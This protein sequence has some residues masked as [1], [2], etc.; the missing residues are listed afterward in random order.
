MTSMYLK[1]PLFPEREFWFRKRFE[2]HLI[3]SFQ[4][5]LQMHIGESRED[6]LERFKEISETLP[7][8]LDAKLK[9][10]VFQG[11]WRWTAETPFLILAT[12]YSLGFYQ[13]NVEALGR[14]FHFQHNSPEKTPCFLYT[15]PCEV[16]GKLRIRLT[17]PD[18]ALFEHLQSILN[19]FKPQKLPK[20]LHFQ[21][22]ETPQPLVEFLQSSNFSLAS[23]ND[24][25]TRG[26]A[27]DP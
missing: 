2:T 14:F 22:W 11:H 16:N 23:Q 12:L 19:R 1:S 3:D 9:P 17:T 6:F 26:N 15:S 20:S 5:W 24:Y 10:Q 27:F 4:L 25:I 21:E 13:T 7:A 18:S 8:M